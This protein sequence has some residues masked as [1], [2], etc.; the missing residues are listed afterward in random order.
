MSGPEKAI[1]SYSFLLTAQYV[2][3]SNNFLYLLEQFKVI[4]MDVNELIDHKSGLGYISILWS[5]QSSEAQK[6]S[7]TFQ[8]FY[9][10]STCRVGP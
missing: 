3:H 8:Y 2:L 6:L 7:L 1:W 4:K 5:Y 10:T 9:T